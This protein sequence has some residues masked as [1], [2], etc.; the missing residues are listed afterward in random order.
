MSTP[1]RDALAPVRLSEEGARAAVPA[2]VNQMMSAFAATFRAG[3]DVNLG[4]GYVSED[5]LPRDA[6]QRALAAVL[7]APERHPH[8][9]NYGGA[10]GS[11]TL[12]AALR[13]FL[14]GRAVGGLTPEL[15]ARRRLVIGSNGVTSLLES[16]ATVLPRGV[17]VTSDPYYYIFADYLRRR[18]FEIVAIPEDHAGLDSDRLAAALPALAERVSFVYVVG[19]SNPT[20]A[21]LANDRRRAL[22]EHVARAS[23]A[24]GRKIPVFFDAAYELIVHDPAVPPPRSAQLGDDLGI[25][26]ELGTLSKA[27]SPALRVGWLMGPD[28]PLLD[29]VVQRT[30]DVGFSA[31]LL[32]QELAAHLLEQEADAQ[33]AR[34]NAGYRAKALAARDLVERHLGDAVEDL[35]GGQAGFYLYLTLRDVETVQ[36]SAFFR[37]CARTTGDPAVDGPPGDPAP[38]VLYVPGELCVHPRGALTTA[39]RRQLRLSY[40]YEDLAGLA[41]GI[42]LL[43]DALAYARAAG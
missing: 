27:F 15:V 32:N 37:A 20:G 28:G 35:V 41:R 25:V 22:V 11:P 3:V 42:G 9:L 6:V 8:A 2:P 19:V 7:A 31:S 17:V 16:L 18:G 14:G 1:R 30:S 36:G 26:Y 10:E 33:L 34:V 40:G 23:R 12:I 13:R 43:S 21:V 38:R 24:I 4:V 39:A 29:A 5:T